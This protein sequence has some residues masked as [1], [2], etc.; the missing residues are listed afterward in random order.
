MCIRD[1][2]IP[3][4]PPVATATLSKGRLIFFWGGVYIGGVYIPPSL[5]PLFQNETGMIQV[6]LLLSEIIYTLTISALFNKIARQSV[7][8]LK[9]LLYTVFKNVPLSHC[10]YLRHILTDFK[11]LSL[12]HPMKNV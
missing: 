12:P 3:I 5:R 6:L 10:P 11:I 7:K 4:Y 1:R 2:Y 8:I 9:R